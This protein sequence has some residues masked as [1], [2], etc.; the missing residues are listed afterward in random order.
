VLELEFRHN[1]YNSM[2][3]TLFNGFACFDL[4]PF[5]VE[6]ED[7]ILIRVIVKE[8]DGDKEYELMYKYN[9]LNKNRVEKA[10]PSITT[11]EYE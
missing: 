9:E 7:S 1:S 10:L 5:R 3:N 6:G 4:R 8:H 11:N 2:S